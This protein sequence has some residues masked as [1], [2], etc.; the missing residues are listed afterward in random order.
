MKAEEFDQLAERILHS[1]L[2]TE[3]FDANFFG[4]VE[5]VRAV[6]VLSAELADSLLTA[7]RDRHERVC[8]RD[9]LTGEEVDL[10]RNDRIIQ[11]IKSVRERT[12]MN[13]KDA[14]SLVDKIRAQLGL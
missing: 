10:L 8:N 11:C 5:A 4:D 1:L 12:G 9:G 14:K 13:L 6:G 2:Q 3:R 7:C